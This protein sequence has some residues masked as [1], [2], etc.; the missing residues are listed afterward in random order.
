MK[1]E[2]SRFEKAILEKLL[3]GD[4]PLFN[5]LRQQLARC[6]VVKREFTGYG[7]YTTLAIPE[8]VRRTVGVTSSLA[9]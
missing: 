6:R 1:N 7:F 8:D 9:T 3:D 5:Q 2:L 4:F